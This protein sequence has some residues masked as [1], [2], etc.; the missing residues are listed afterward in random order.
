M[1]SIDTI[2]QTIIDDFSEIGDSF[3][4]YAYLIELACSLPPLAEEKKTPDRLVEGCQSQV[5][6]DIRCENGMFFFSSDSNTLIVKGV[7]YLL[8]QMFNGQRCNDVAA[9]QIVFLQ[10]TSIMYT[11]ESDRQKG[12]QYVIR[13][14]KRAAGQHAAAG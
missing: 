6:L 10:E 13:E 2:Q 4:Q 7:L 11:F 5:W 12:L 1:N 9:A 3:D 14:L 8:E